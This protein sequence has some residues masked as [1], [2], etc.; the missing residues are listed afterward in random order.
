MEISNFYKYIQL[1]HDAYS[2]GDDVRH[3]RLV[4]Y[5]AKH[6]ELMGC[7][8]YEFFREAFIKSRRN[9]KALYGKR[10]DLIGFSPDLDELVV[11]EVKVGE[12][13]RS[14]ARKDF[15]LGVISLLKRTRIVG[16]TSIFIS[17]RDE[18]SALVSRGRVSTLSDVDNIAW[19]NKRIALPEEYRGIYAHVVR[20]LR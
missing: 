14:G 1:H 7:E 8:D 9:G 19:H 12:N 2:K 4:D 17:A 13:I 6:P 18:R 16:A 20:R 5:L 10:F 15:S 3:L 11:G